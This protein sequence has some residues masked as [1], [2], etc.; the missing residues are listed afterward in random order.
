M[1]QNMNEQMTAASRQMADTVAEMGRLSLENA[2]TV[3][4]LHM[5]AFQDSAN[6]TFAFFGEVSEARDMDSMKAV[7]P[8]GAQVARE[9]I[10][11]N[12]ATGQEIFGRTL[13][14]NE[15]IAQIAK[16][17]VESASAT[18]QA[19]AE[20]AVKATTKTRK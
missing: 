1:Y 5:S 4:G 7:L 14:T 20:K 19:E 6:A 12:V 2:E 17:Q 11:R 16:S 10:E 3:F 18:V 8:K 9:S 15:A 13:K